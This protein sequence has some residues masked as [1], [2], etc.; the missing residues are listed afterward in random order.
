MCIQIYVCILIRTYKCSMLN[1]KHAC[2][3]AGMY[4]TMSTTMYARM[5]VL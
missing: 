1:I 5:Q 4:F 3:Q 2:V